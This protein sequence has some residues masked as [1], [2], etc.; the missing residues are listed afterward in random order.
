[1]TAT[2]IGMD[3]PAAAPPSRG[4][5]PQEIL[6][7][8]RDRVEYAFEDAPGL[9]LW[10]ALDAAA[11]E[12]G[13]DDRTVVWRGRERRAQH[14]A[15]MAARDALDDALGMTKARAHEIIDAAI[16]RLNEGGDV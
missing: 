15:Y 12:L 6:A 13:A 11:A 7:L 9:R 16:Q 8:T 2:Q 4:P 10:H 3:M 5:T 1:M 14:P